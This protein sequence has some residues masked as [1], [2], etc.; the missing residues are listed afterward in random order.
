MNIGN[1]PPAN[2]IR[3]LKLKFE[4]PNAGMPGAGLTWT[5]PQWGWP[6]DVRQS[7]NRE[8]WPCNFPRFESS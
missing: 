6:Q 1:A 4:I 7:A 3:A 5:M 8:A 2:F